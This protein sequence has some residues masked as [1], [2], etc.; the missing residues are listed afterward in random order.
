MAQGQT[1]I[2]QV[3][4][5]ATTTPPPPSEAKIENP[6]AVTD[7]TNEDELL[8]A[9]PKA[10]P[11]AL[12]SPF[13]L[14]PVGINLGERTIT[15]ATLVRGAENGIQAVDFSRWSIPYNEVLKALQFTATPLENN[16]VE[17]RSPAAV[18]RLDLT[19]LTSDPQLGLVF[20]VA[21]IRDLLQVPVE[22]DIAEY[23]IVFTPE[24]LGL[25]RSGLGARYPLPERPIILE[26]L[27]RLEAPDLTISTIAQ[28]T[29]ISGGGDQPTTYEGEMIG[30]G[31]FFGGSWYSKIDQPDLTDSRTWQLEELQY[32]RQTPSTDYVIGDQQ[33]FWPEGSGRYTGLSIIRRFGFQPPNIFTSADDGFNPQQRLNSDR[34]ERDIR[35]RAEPGT[36]VQLVNKNGN[37]IIG[38]QLVDNTG[39][40]RFENIASASTTRGSGGLSG[41]RYELRL[42]PDGQL[43]AFPE[44]RDAQFTSLP[45]QLS[46]GTSAILLSAGFERLR[47]G[48]RFFG[49][50][51]D[52]LQGGI[53]YRWGATENLTLGT[54]LFYDEQLKGLGEFFFQPGRLPLRVTGSATF[55]SDEQRGE[56]KGDTRYDLNLRFNPSQ[57]FDFEFDKDELSERIRARWEPSRDLRLAFNSSSGNQTAQVTWRIFPGVSSQ[58]GW[59]FNEKALEGGINFGGSLALGEVLISNSLNFNADESPDWRLR[60]Q[61]KNLSLDHRL[62][63]QQIS[64]ELE[65]FFR[66]SARRS[67]YNHSLFSRYQ[68]SDKGA[69]ELV[70]TGWRYS[71]NSSVGDRLS[72]WNINLGYGIGTQGTGWQVSLGT[73]QLFGLSLTA[74]YQDISL[75]SNEPSFSIL[76]SSNA[77]LSPTLS[78]KPSRFERLRTEG[79]IAVIPFI[80]SNGNGMQDRDEPIYLEGINAGTADFLFLINDQ[81]GSRFS[82]YDAD[83]RQRGIFVRLPPDIY[84]FDVDPAGLPLGWQTSQSAFAVEVNAGSYTPIYL[85]LIRSYI[86]AGI[87]VNNEGRPVG[88]IRVEAI[89]T[90]NPRDRVFSVTNGAGI[91]YLESLGLGEYE[92]FID[93][94]PATPRL[95]RVEA[96]FEEITEVNLQAQ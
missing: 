31:T 24:W 55:N 46:Q 87:V 10:A 48:D 62:R 57:R 60:A 51:D 12:P 36:L 45:G 89:S 95:L 71:S 6:N 69:N 25:Q 78:L 29:E 41:N 1:L 3:T 42:Y 2:T 90:E 14:I 77:L 50:L 40:F 39:I 80:D 74:R 93:G 22:F 65:Y 96:D 92:L 56:E 76:L 43:S 19:E 83:L 4:D 54:G 63:N 23:A 86:V 70:V 68:N 17:L 8:A 81:P 66:N 53:A 21:Q 27:P 34:L 7:G 58:L 94:K 64:S 44:I 91:Y 11:K 16:L 20:T 75:S 47:Q 32:L 28:E 26:G 18:L 73:N 85:P 72:N 38:E 67:D 33:T 15:L 49:S 88:G 37:I 30:I 59:N 84:R 52:Q 35:G 61:Y 82:E 79:G 13:D 9:D 5:K